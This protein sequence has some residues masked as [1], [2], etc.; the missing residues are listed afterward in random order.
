MILMALSASFTPGQARQMSSAVNEYNQNEAAL[1]S[2]MTMMN[3]CVEL[4]TNGSFESGS[5]SPWVESSNHA[6]T[7]LS[8]V[9]PRESTYSAFLGDANRADDQLYQEII[10][11]LDATSL[12]LTYWYTTV[13]SDSP[14]QDVMSITLR[15]G[16][17]ERLRTLNSI[18]ASTNLEWQQATHDL[19]DYRGQ[20]LQIHF[21]AITGSNDRSNFSLD[22][23][24]VQACGVTLPTATP[25]ATT[26]AQHELFLPLLLSGG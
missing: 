6:K 24:S 22:D 20:S 7:L 18:E 4:L 17:G 25:T 16:K 5:I 26:T 21:R 11:P 3:A 9:R 2:N 23:I 10:L 15:S 8:T 19:M 12:T 13:A 14:G 1:G